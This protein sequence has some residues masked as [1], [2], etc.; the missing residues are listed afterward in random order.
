MQKIFPVKTIQFILVVVA[1]IFTNIYYPANAAEPSIVGQ[2]NNSLTFAPSTADSRSQYLELSPG[3]NFGSSPFTFETYFKTGSTLDNGFFLGVGSG[4]GLS[5]NIYS[6]N[7]IQIDAYGINA[8]IFVLP[9]SMQVNTWYHIA[10]ARDANNN[11]TV[12][13][14]GARATSA[15]NRWT[16]SI[17]YGPIFVDT[18][19]YNGQTTGINGSTACAHCNNNHYGDSRSNVDFSGVRITN[20]RVVVGSTIYDPN[21]ATITPPDAPLSNVTNTKLLLN[22]TNSSS[23]TTD[24]SGTQT[25]T[26]T[27]VTFTAAEKITPSFTWSNVTKNYGDSPFTIISPTTSISGTFTYSSASTGVITLNNVNTDSATVVAPGTSVITAS[28]TPTDTATYNSATTTMTVTVGKATQ[29]TLSLALSQSSKNSPYSQAI[30]FSTTGGSGSGAINYAIAAGGT[31]TGC[32]LANSTETNTV[33][34]TSGGTCLIQ[35]TKSTD[36]NYLVATSATRIFTFNAPLSLKY[37]VGD[38]GTGTAPTLSGT[39]FAGDTATVAAGSTL[40]RVGFT[41][42]GWRNSSNISVAA[43]STFTFSTNDTLT[44]QWRQSSLF[45]ISDGDLTEIQSWNASANTNSGTVSNPANTSAVTVTVPGGSLPNGTT[46]KL[47]ELANANLARAKVSADKD[48][49]VN[50]VLSWLKSDGTVPTAST[51]ITIAISNNTIQSGATAY[52]IIG[53]TVT[54]IGTATTAGLIN[55]SITEDPVIVIANPVSSGGGGSSGGSGGGGGAMPSNTAPVEVAKPVE[56][57]KPASNLETFKH[58]VTFGSGASWIN[59]NNIKLLRTFIGD[60]STSIEIKKITIQGY[61]Q[62]TKIQ[63]K[64]IDMARANSVAKFLKK[65]GVSSNFIVEGKGSSPTKNGAMSRIAVVI[66]EGKTKT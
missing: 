40:S 61:A 6:P 12:W 27:G 23:A 57:A 13:L 36:A 10:V 17:T 19:N 29:S 58:I 54:Q 32:A 37:A 62:P 34:A 5:I 28:F 38:S 51:P 44:A 1:L 50:L 60:V 2:V 33:T 8:T 59:S 20:F 48:Y 3:I 46:V 66:I 21:S 16:R 30:T 15:Y 22:V 45:G 25:I 55:L 64:N 26:N 53:D 43:G 42:N 18:R 63:L 35:A 65:E 49:I 11:E 9:T 47:W 56:L 41:F 39:Y 52:Q 31:A 7:E 14:N 4:N 24:S